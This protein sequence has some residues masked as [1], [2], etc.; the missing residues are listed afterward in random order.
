[1]KYFLGADSLLYDSQ[2]YASDYHSMGFRDC[3]GEVAR[4]LSMVEG[5]ELQDPVRLRL[6]SHLQ[7]CN[8][9]RIASTINPWTTQYTG[10]ANSWPATASSVPKFEP[11]PV[12]YSSPYASLPTVDVSNNNG[13][14]NGN[15]NTVH[16]P[17]APVVSVANQAHSLTSLRAPMAGSFQPVG[18]G[19]ATGLNLNLTF[20]APATT[21]NGPAMTSN[22]D[23]IGYGRN[24]WNASDNAY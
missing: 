16:Y 22:L 4:Y 9:Q 21:S 10:N 12:Q 7:S 5:M 8:A 1:M 13:Y 3:A 6:L 20:L 24:G 2:R 11:T 14:S 19:S 17:S 23:K 18:N 15:L